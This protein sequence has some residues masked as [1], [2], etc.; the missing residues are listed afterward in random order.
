MYDIVVLGE[1]L[2]DF[3]PNGISENGNPYFERNPGGGPANMACAVAKLGGKVAFLAQVGNDMFGQALKKTVAKQNVD[4]TQVRVSD[5][6]KTTLAFVGLDE[7]G[8]RSF[9]FYRR[10]GADTMM[11]TEDY[12]LSV[13]K[14]TKYFFLSSVLMAEGTSR[15]TSFEILEEVKKIGVPIVFDPN[16]R[17]NLW[18]D[19]SKLKECVCKALTYADIVKV[20]DEELEYIMDNN[21]LEEAARKMKEEFLIGILLV[22]R[23]KDGCIA[24]TDY[25]IVKHEGF[26]VEKPVD[27]TA[28]G[29]SFT[30]GFLSTLVSYD[31]N[32]SECSLEE[33]EKCLKIGNAVGSLTV[34]KRGA[35]SALPNWDDVKKIIN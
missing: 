14:D 3:T 25:G 2:V 8:E 9:S 24:Y 31:K 20:S 1:L 18:E 13:L 15:E 17:F 27:T 29:D 34:T 35:I 4:C 7:S 21:N 26:S 16:L 12:D 33:I 11:R 19:H 6:Y 23:G 32:Y 30:G 22:T 5:E 28:A 10:Y